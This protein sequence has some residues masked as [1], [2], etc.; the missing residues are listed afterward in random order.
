MIYIH[1]YTYIQYKH[2]QNCT[3]FKLDK[4]IQRQ[5]STPVKAEE[6]NY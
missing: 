4:S 2:T 6:G 3:I 1:I 5:N